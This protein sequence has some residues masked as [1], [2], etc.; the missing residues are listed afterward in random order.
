[1][2]LLLVHESTN[3]RIQGSGSCPRAAILRDLP[4]AF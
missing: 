4:W 3:A 2:G 1:M